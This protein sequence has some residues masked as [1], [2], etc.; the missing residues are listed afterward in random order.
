MDIEPFDLIVVGAGSGG[1]RASRIAAQRGLKVAV[2]EHSRVGGTCVIR[3]CVPKKLLMYASQFHDQWLDARGFGWALGELPRHDWPAL[4]AAVGAEV[5]RLEKVYHGLLAGAGVTLLEGH[6]TLQARDQVRVG[7]RVLAAPRI[8]LATGAQPAPLA[9]AGADLAITSDD[10]FNLPRMPQRLLVVGGGFI[11][12]EF[13]GIFKRLGS[14]VVLAHRGDR[15]LRGFD[16]DVRRHLAEEL[17]AGGLD[18]RWGWQPRAIALRPDGR[19]RVTLASATGT[20]EEDF[21]AV[22][23]ATGRVPATAGLG[24]ADIGVALG[25]AGEIVVDERSRTSVP[26]IWAVGDCTN[27]MNLT[28]VALREGHAVA[29]D[30]TDGPDLPIDYLTVPQAVFSQPP[31]AAVGHTEASARA[32]FAAV[33]IYRATFK[34]MRATISGRAERALMKLIVRRDTQQVVGAHMVGNDAPEILQGLAIAVN[35]GLTKA[36]FDATVGIH[37]T[38][39][40]EFVTMRTPVAG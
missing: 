34:P 30:L 8:L 16:E 11:A 18:A 22:L 15:P 28:P 37:P 3:G 12:L 21:D 5:T 1:V 25:A 23:L 4:V 10:C 33:D 20:V 2:T 13:A 7:D 39:A 35:A 29:H 19:R 6:A 17:A 27:R 14:D 38:A 40:E 9:I 24:L 31:V 32:A 26:G 36:Q